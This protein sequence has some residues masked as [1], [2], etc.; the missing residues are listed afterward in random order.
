MPFTTSTGRV[1]HAA[2]YHFTDG[3]SLIVWFNEEGHQVQGHTVAQNGKPVIYAKP[4]DVLL[5]KGEP[6]TIERV[7]GY[8]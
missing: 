2:Q 8:R 6:K 5:F 1:I 4:G 3:R 7:E